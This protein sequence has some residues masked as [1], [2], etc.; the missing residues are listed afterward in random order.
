MKA[1]PPAAAKHSTSLEIRAVRFEDVPDILRLV[2]SAISVGCRDHYDPAQRAAVYASYARTL[3][4]DSLGPFESVAVEQAGRIIGFAQLDVTDERLRALFVEADHQ[5][6]GLGRVL[7][8][9]IEARAASHGCTRLHGAMS[10]NAI[11][12]YLQAG[13][14]PCHGPERL[15]TSGIAV[16]IVRMEK[17]LRV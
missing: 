12:F 11:P 5:R 16:P 9:D 14:H 15:V 13:F 2:R 10:L 8:G 17:R 3:F 4:V 1:R 6:R 7:L